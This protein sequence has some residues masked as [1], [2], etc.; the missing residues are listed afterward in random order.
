MPRKE[1][2]IKCSACE[3]RLPREG[4]SRHWAWVVDKEYRY[5]YFCSASCLVAYMT[6]IAEGE[7]K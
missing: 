2:L 4:A 1:P 5:P 7:E 6:P 3:R